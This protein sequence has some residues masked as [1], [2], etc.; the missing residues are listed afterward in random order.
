MVYDL[1]F[2]TTRLTLCITAPNGTGSEWRIEAR[3]SQKD[4]AFVVG[5]SAQTRREALEEVGRLWSEHAVQQRVPP[6]DWEGA[7]L[8]LVAVRAI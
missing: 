6:F 3:T 8:A 5:G 7:T 2:Q 1:K 4:D